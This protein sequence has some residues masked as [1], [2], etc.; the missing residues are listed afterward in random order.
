MKA[1]KLILKQEAKTEIS[2]AYFWYKDKQE[3]LG[4]RFLDAV[5]KQFLII[6]N[7]PKIFAK[8]YNNM[9]QAPVKEFP[10]VI[11]YEIENNNIV[12]FAVFHTSRNPSVWGK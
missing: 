1:Y 8:K 10:Y 11:I 12:V 3:R 9:R 6:A 7:N 5:D 4:K 2:N